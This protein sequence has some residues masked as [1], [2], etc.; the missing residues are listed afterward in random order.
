M[1]FSGGKTLRSAVH[2]EQPST[3]VHST[4][5]TACVPETYSAVLEYPEERRRLPG[6]DI[7]LIGSIYLLYESVG[8]TPE[9]PIRTHPS[10]NDIGESKTAICFVD[11]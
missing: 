1:R 11:V 4:C 7:K 2:G 6:Q 9:V 10:S 5:C 8:C 3:P